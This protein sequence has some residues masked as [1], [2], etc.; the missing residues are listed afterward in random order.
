MSFFKPQILVILLLNF[1]AME[2]NFSQAMPKGELMDELRGLKGKAFSQKALELSNKLIIAQK[3]KA[4]TLIAHKSFEEAKSNESS[5]WMIRSLQMEAMAMIAEGDYKRDIGITNLISYKLNEAVKLLNKSKSNSLSIFNEELKYSVSKKLT[6]RKFGRHIQEIQT[7]LRKFE[8]E[9][10]ASLNQ[11]DIKFLSPSSQVLINQTQRQ[12]KPVN[13][14]GQTQS[15]QKSQDELF[16]TTKLSKSELEYLQKELKRQQDLVQG[17]TA[18]QARTALFLEKQKSVMDSLLYI[19]T[20]DSMALLTKNKEIKE[21]TMMLKLN[22]SQRNGAFAGLGLIASVA[23]G[24][25]FRARSNKKFGNKLHE[26]NLIIEDEK[27]RNEKLLLNI[28]PVTVAEELKLHGRAKPRNFEKVSI[29]F[30]DFVNFTSISEKM[31]P[32]ELVEQLDYCFRKFDEI[33]LEHN[34]EKIKTIGDSYMAAG[35]LPVEDQDNPIRAV[36]A[37]IAIQY[38]LNEWKVSSMIANKPFFEARVGLHCGPVTAGVVGHTKF[39]YDI[40]GDT[41]N[42]AS[43]IESASEPGKINLSEQMFDEVKDYFKTEHRGHLPVKHKHE[44]KMYFVEL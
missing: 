35:G 26:K 18:D 16:N 15:V 25:F 42:T 12:I 3:Y 30:T 38:F 20:M 44:M 17:L 33:M 39:A 9:G 8:S 28:L 43:R 7:L 22:Q 2:P 37:A 24:F 36:K 5:D 6:G 29:L 34:L 40:W 23:L 31:S 10:I 32:S 19:S 14:Q 4:A 21:K 27:A 41:V 1:V 11:K 13:L